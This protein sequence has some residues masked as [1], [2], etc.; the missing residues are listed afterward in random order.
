[1]L[2][3][4]RLLPAATRALYFSPE[5]SFDSY[6]ER[7]TDKHRKQWVYR[8]SLFRQDLLDK[9]ELAAMIRNLTN[10][11]MLVVAL[12]TTR[13]NSSTAST[14]YRSLANYQRRVLR[15]ATAAKSVGVVLTDVEHAPRVSAVLATRQLSHLRVA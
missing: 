8:A 10:L 7:R 5:F 12:P 13:E 15:L 11:P 6:P 1:M 3:C 2:T 4:K 9:P 14:T